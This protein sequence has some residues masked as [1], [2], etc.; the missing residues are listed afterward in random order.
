MT[1]KIEIHD[2]VC[3]K[4]QIEID[5][6][7]KLTPKDKPKFYGV[8]GSNCMITAKTNVVGDVETYYFSKESM[9]EVQAITGEIIPRKV[10]KLVSKTTGKKHAD[11]KTK[12]TNAVTV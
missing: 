3:G 12:T 7:I 10:K 1:K 2:I 4:I 6:I 8:K 5:D 9:E 11:K